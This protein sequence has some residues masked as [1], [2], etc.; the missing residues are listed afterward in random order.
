MCQSGWRRA[1]R[2]ATCPE[3][4]SIAT[5]SG[6][7]RLR[8]SKCTA[9]GAVNRLATMGN[10]NLK[11]SFGEERTPQNNGRKVLSRLSALPARREGILREDIFHAMLTLER[12]RAERSRKQFVL[13][14]LDSQAVQKNGNGANFL[15]QLTSIVCD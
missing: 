14:L 1:E 11:M 6:C 3:Y 5:G 9:N 7:L 12:R 13:M 15:E 2:F 8:F 4:S 10:S